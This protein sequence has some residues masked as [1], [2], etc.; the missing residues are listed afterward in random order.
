MRWPRRR[1]CCGRTPRRPAAAGGRR[2]RRWPRCCGHSGT[3]W[4]RRGRGRPGPYGPGDLTRMRMLA[5]WTAGLGG[6][7]VGSTPLNAAF[8]D[9]PFEPSPYL[10]VS[11]LHWNELYADPAASP[12]WAGS[13]RARELAAGVRPPEGRL[14]DYRAAAAA[15][16][17]VLEALLADL[18]GERLDAF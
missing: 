17:R 14:I 10:P 11:R 2:R 6:D 1:A 7:L 9:E 3:A 8:L 18:D 4:T 15:K 13:A 5:E 16:R 12:E